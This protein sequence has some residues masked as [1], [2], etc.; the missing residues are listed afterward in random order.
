MYRILNVLFFTII[1]LASQTLA[2]TPPADFLE[3]IAIC[4][5][6]DLRL[7]EGLWTYPED[8]VTVLIIRNDNKKGVY[9][10]L[11]VESA[12]C[13]LTPGM[14]LGELH[15][16]VDPDKFN[17]KLFTKVRNGIL[18]APSEAI[19]TFSASKETLTV[20]KSGGIN[21]RLNP[22]RLLPYFW[23]IASISFKSKEYA[24]EGMIKIYPS[25]DGNNSSRRGP[26][27]L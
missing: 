8:D 18:S 19:A 24:P 13:S 2:I 20:R 27:Y 23:R 6:T 12:D 7:V 15:E 21:F 17:L 26:R 4:D 1:S 10:I 5:N 3:A 25:Y 11:V 22:T 14:T 16:S 9:D